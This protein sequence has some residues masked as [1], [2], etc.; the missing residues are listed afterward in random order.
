M[1][2]RK[3]PP[4]VVTATKHQDGWSVSVQ[5]SDRRSK[6]NT[7]ET[8]YDVEDAALEMLLQALRTVNS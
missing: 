4:I 3:V 7:I 5:P 6:L 2:M 8:F 1:Q